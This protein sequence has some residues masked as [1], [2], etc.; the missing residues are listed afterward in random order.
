MAELVIAYTKGPYY[1]GG[2]SALVVVC[3]VLDANAQV[4]GDGL[5]DI[6]G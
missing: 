1:F 4:R 6:G 5:V 2:A 3:A